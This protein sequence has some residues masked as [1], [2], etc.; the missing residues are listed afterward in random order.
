MLTI[1]KRWLLDLTIVVAD[2]AGAV[3]KGLIDGLLG[4]QGALKTDYE[5]NGLLVVNLR[6][7]TAHQSVRIALGGTMV[8]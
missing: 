7:H 3:V 5:W 2:K 4:G 6:Q 1:I 8:A